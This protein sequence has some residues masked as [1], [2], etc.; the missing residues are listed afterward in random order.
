MPHKYLEPTWP[1]KSNTLLDY[2]S[3]RSEIISV[4]WESFVILFNSKCFYCDKGYKESE[5]DKDHLVPKSKG[6][7]GSVNYVLS[8]KK[9]NKSKGDRMPTQ[10]EL[11]K[12]K[13]IWNS[14]LK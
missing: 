13:L 8:C 12:A 7:R 9:C 6:G 4:T 3:T 5:F 10:E 11:N 14:L 2:F 1:D